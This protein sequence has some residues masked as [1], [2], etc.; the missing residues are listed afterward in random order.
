MLVPKFRTQISM[1]GFYHRIL[2]MTD[3]RLTKQ[4][5]KWDKE[6]NDQKRIPSWFSEIKLIFNDNRMSDLINENT[7]LFNLKDTVDKLKKIMHEKQAIGLQQ[8][9]SN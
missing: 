4:I 1:V 3:E 7:P 8:E 9:C 2:K 6:M 5:F